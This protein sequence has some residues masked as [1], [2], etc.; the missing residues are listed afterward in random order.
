MKRE[1]QK[2]FTCKKQQ[3]AQ[4][5]AL[6]T[7]LFR[8]RQYQE[9]RSL[10]IPLLNYIKTNTHPPIYYLPKRS[11]PKTDSLLQESSKALKGKISRLHIYF[12]IFTKKKKLKKLKILT[13]SSK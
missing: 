6:E 7:K 4:V 9:W 10:Q 8:S 1:R 2:L 11:N 13:Q 12:L 3:L 5:K